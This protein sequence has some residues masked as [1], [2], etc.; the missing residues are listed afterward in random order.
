AAAAFLFLI[1][2]SFNPAADRLFQLGVFA[3]G[4]LYVGTFFLAQHGFIRLGGAIIAGSML[5]FVTFFGEP[6][7]ILSGTAGAI[8]LIP[9]LIAGMV[10]GAKAVIPTGALALILISA[11]PLLR[12]VAWNQRVVVTLFVLGLT[13]ALLWLIIRI[14]EQ[15]LE[16]ARKQTVA[17]EQDKAE[18]AA[19]EVSLQTANGN[20]QAANDQLED[21]LRLV[22]ELETPVIPLLEQVLVAPLVGHLDTRRAEQVTQAVLDTVY[23]QKATTVIIDIT[24]IQVMDTQVVQHLDR[25]AQAVQLLGAHVVMTGIRPEVAQTITMLG[26]SFNNIRTH[27]RLQ[28]GVMAVLHSAFRVSSN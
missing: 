16:R 13:T 7:N 14:L 20:L 5:L 4:C 19:R 26:L 25:L 2:T 9:I 1:Q 12:G 23:S 10:I 3:I 22:R 24:G 21:L 27:S 18:I 8:Y 15:A 11:V 17:A 6:E 28:D